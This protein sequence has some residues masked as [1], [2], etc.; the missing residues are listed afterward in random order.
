MDIVG[1]INVR[2]IKIPLS[3][4]IKLLNIAYKY[5][6]DEICPNLKCKLTE[7]NIIFSSLSML[8]YGRW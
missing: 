7:P 2:G 3:L 5:C 4:N 8:M 6:K 1:K